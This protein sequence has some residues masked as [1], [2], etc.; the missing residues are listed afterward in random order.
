MTV[1]LRQAI[2]ADAPQ[3]RGLGACAVVILPNPASVGL[4]T[5]VGFTQVGL[6]LWVGRKFGQ[7]HDIAWFPRPL[8][9]SRVAHWYKPPRQTPTVGSGCGGV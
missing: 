3:G 8:R 7:W 5:A 6:S 2:L 9:A 4:P 1:N